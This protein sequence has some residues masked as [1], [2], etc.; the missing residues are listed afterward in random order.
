MEVLQVDWINTTLEFEDKV[1]DLE[2]V[3][4]EYILKIN[5]GKEQARTVKL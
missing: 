5:T 1:E 4:K 2:H 3:C